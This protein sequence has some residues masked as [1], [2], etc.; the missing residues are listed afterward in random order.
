VSGAGE[1]RPGRYWNPTSPMA[2]HGTS[3]G[4]PALRSFH[5]GAHGC[6]AEPLISTPPAHPHGG[7]ARAPANWATGEK[8][9]TPRTRRQAASGAQ[10]TKRQKGADLSE[11]SGKVQRPAK[12]ASVRNILRRTPR[13]RPP[14]QLGGPR[15]A[16][17]VKPTCRSPRER[18][19]RGTR[20]TSRPRL[21][22][23]R[24]WRPPPRPRSRLSRRSRRRSAVPGRSSPRVWH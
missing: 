4:A 13:G 17:G 14:G 19:G 7:G 16:S 11:A 8:P 9:P 21:P 15:T 23:R 12:Q 1:P 22:A 5:P 20:G 2:E 24:G 6:G 18:S 3:P 10:A